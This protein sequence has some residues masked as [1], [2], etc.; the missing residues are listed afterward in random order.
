MKLRPMFKPAFVLAAVRLALYGPTLKLSYAKK[1]DI[2]KGYDALYTEDGDEWKLTSVEGMKSQSDVDTLK[3][4]LEKEKNDHKKAKQELAAWKKLGESPEAVHTQLDRIP[5]LET[6]A[7]G[8]GSDPAKI[9]ALVDAKVKSK[10]AALNRELETLRATNEELTTTN[11]ELG[12]K[13]KQGKIE[14]QIRR[15]AEASG[16]LP[17]AIDDLVM[18]GDRFFDVA[19][20][21]VVQTREGPGQKA[22]LTV[23]QWL[24]N[25]KKTRP[26]LWPASTGGGARG[27]NGH[28]GGDPNA[29]PWSKE[30]WNK[31]RQALYVREHGEQKATEFAKSVG[32]D[33][34]SMRPPEK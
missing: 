27:G 34:H 2:P 11:N 22:G 7:E 10:T 18:M 24:T 9:D 20:D 4:A 21:D 23:E 8:K 12:G 32:S 15:H 16:V 5:E 31:T 28:G 29:N 3:G 14:S 30:G 6:L 19:D 26:H 33:L 1:E 13:I 25:Q 17:A